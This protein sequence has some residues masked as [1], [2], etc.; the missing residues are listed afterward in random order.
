MKTSY[1]AVQVTLACI[2]LS[3]PVAHDFSSLEAVASADSTDYW[4]TSG[5]RYSTP[6]EQGINSAYLE[7]M[8]DY[9]N[10]QNLFIDS[11]IVVRH[12]YVILEEYGNPYQQNNTHYL[13][14][15]TKS[16]SSALIGIALEEG[17]IDSISHKVL[18]FFPNRSF[19]NMSAWKQAIT[20]EHL[21]AMTSGIPFSDEVDSWQMHD[22]NDAVQFVL[23]RSVTSEPGT[24]WSYS[25]GGSHLLSAIVNV[26]TGMDTLEFAREHLFDPL[27]ISALH[28]GRDA[29]GIPWGHAYLFMRALDMAKFGYLYLHSG[30]WDGQQIV[31]AEWVAESTSMN[32]YFGESWG[33]GYQWWIQ[34]ETGTYDCYHYCASG[35]LGQKIYVIPN[36]DM[37]VVFTASSE[38]YDEIEDYMLHQFILRARLRMSGDVYWDW[39]VD[40]FDLA[41]VATQ[42]GRPPPPISDSR[43]DINKDG[44]VDIFDVVVV[45]V[46][47]GE[48]S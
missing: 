3:A 42:F 48:T 12:G 36:Y 44:T 38:H 7:N 10:S 40:I 33:Y 11:V 16:F 21:L 17:Y 13:A 41:V 23:D 26:T 5:W 9:I 1:F 15:V 31:P 37:V 30:M 29:M 46:H 34:N 43:A 18:D 32:T 14:S 25:S 27:G 22:S 20:L 35:A 45:A 4:P 8:K 2:I 6:E 47:F 19:A 28:W 39:T 24:V